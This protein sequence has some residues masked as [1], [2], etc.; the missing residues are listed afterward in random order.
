MPEFEPAGFLDRNACLGCGST[1]LTTVASG[2]YDEGPLAGFIAADPW[3]ED[4][5]PHLRGLPWS[6]VRCVP[7]GL[8][9]HRYVL[10]PAWNERRFSRWMSGSA[11]A[12][13]EARLGGGVQAARAAHFTEH[14]LRICSRFGGEARSPSLPAVRVL[15]YGCGNGE[16]LAICGAFGLDPIGV[17]R[18]SARREHAAGLPVYADLASA[19]GHGPFDVITLF[20]V[21]EHVDD[22]MALLRELRAVLANEA[23]L[24]VETPDCTGIDG[25]RTRF[26]YQRIHPLDHI[27][28]FEPASLRKL[29]ESAGFVAESRPFALATSDQ[30]VAAR[31][32]AKSI[33]R[34]GTQETT[35]MYFRKR[36]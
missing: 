17:D 5:A 2:R 6:L 11:I 18:S 21:L 29:V 3:G 4:P 36:Q 22:P 31:R 33:L 16:F 14:A 19:R 9:F 1:D 12:E 32:L 34:H 7:C 8:S 27:N 23:L 30:R 10:D 24:I 26:D 28:A 15:D 35:Q 13:F 20:E 25:I